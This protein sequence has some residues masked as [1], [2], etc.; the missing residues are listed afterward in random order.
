MMPEEEAFDL[1]V[2]QGDEKIGISEIWKLKNIEIP[3]NRRRHADMIVH[4][5]EK[6]FI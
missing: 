6:G 1:D 4:A 2:I 3:E 5:V